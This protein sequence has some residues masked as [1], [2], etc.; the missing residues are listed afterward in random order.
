MT[1][2]QVQAY[3]SK[4]KNPQKLA[5]KLAS[6]AHVTRATKNMYMDD[7]TVLVVDINADEVLGF[8]ETI[9]CSC[10]LS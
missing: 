7:I 10:S 1:E 3:V 6:T 5:V 8:E 9:N 2:E 4:I